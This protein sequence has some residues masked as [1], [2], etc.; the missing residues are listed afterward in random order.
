MA[1]VFLPVSNGDCSVRG[2][3]VR[4]RGCVV[5][6]VLR[7]STAG[8]SLVELL[9]V[10]VIIGALVGL[11]LPAVQASREAARQT[12]CKNNLRQLALG[13]NNF[14][15]VHTTFPIG[16]MGHPVP[17]CDDCGGGYQVNSWNAQLLPFLDQNSLA[18][19]EERRVGKECRA[20]R[21]PCH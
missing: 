20:R 16:S 14:E 9:V 7:C 21:S 3:A 2:W 17:G 1:A 6:R 4:G 19:S 18:R 12:Q 5:R 15:T 8:F 13:L 11:M 10:I